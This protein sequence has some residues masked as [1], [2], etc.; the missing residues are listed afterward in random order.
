MMMAQAQKEDRYDFAPK[1][2]NM[3]IFIFTSFMLF[4]AWTSGFIVYVGGKPHGINIQ[5]PHSLLY[6]SIT[7]LISSITLFIASRAAKT[8]DFK[9]QRLFLWGTLALGLVFLGL[10]LYTLDLL[11]KLGA[12]FSNP[13]AA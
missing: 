12:Y 11:V 9:K 4:A 2:F 10:Q 8:L 7:I 6:S 3:W 13:N 5:L 1:K